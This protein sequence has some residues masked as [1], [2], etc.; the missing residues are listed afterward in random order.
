MGLTSFAEV[1]QS[2]Y[3]I[4]YDNANGNKVHSTTCRFVTEDN[5][6]KKVLDNKEQ[7]GYYQS[8]QT[9]NDLTDETV[10]PCKVCKPH[11]V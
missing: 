11:P 9:L 6:N 10:V 2:N 1:L 7:N 4:I 8:L 3:V 5:F